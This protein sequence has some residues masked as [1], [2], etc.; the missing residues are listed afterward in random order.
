VPTVTI[1]VEKCSIEG[2]EL[3]AVAKGYCSSHYR[4]YKVYGDPLTTKRRF[5]GIE[6]KVVGMTLPVAI[7][8]AA[9]AS[10]EEGEAGVTFLTKMILES[11]WGKDAL[12]N[13]GIDLANVG[14]V[15]ATRKG[16]NG[17]EKP[18]KRR[19]KKDE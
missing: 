13:A 12:G 18:K 14:A 16:N 15:V 2:C 11:K 5:N 3:P 10:A 9:K 8:E 6:T 17:E 1:E 7:V 4:R 19:K